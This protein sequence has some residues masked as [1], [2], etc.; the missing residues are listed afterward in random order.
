MLLPPK[1]TLAALRI[2]FSDFTLSPSASAQSQLARVRDPQRDGAHTFLALDE[3]SIRKQATDADAL[4]ASGVQTPALAGITVSIKDLFDV[5]GECTS[6]GAAV[7]RNRHQI[8]AVDCEAVARLKRAGAITF[9]RTNMV[10]FAYAGVGLNPHFGTPRCI[11]GRDADDGVGRIPGG[12]SSGAAVSVAEGF[13]SAALGSDT[14]GSV[15]IPAAFNGLVGFKP[16]AR[17]VPISGVLPLSATL[18]SV[19]ALANSVDCCAT[20]DAVLANEQ[21]SDW[22]KSDIASMR[23]LLPTGALW[24]AL[25]D[26]VRFACEAAVARIEAVGATVVRAAS[27]MIEEYFEIGLHTRIVGPEALAWHRKYVSLN[28]EGYDPRVWQRMQ[29]AASCMID[30]YAA[31]LAYRRDWIARAESELAP[32]CGVISPTIACIAQRIAPLRKDDALY[33]ATNTR[34]LRNTAWVNFLDGCALTIPCQPEGAAPAGL[35]IASVHGEDRRLLSIGSALESI[36]R[37]PSL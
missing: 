29:L 20:I 25:D 5:G 23:F 35:Q 10:E 1:S 22:P 8:A 37:A 34:I 21:T 19:G 15:R 36:I 2:V 26:E 27:P 16:T 14:G 31:A 6:A 9:G 3:A 17:R 11:W 28:G 7:L 4:F 33:F 30:E 13:C 24:F 12:S 18:D 32:Y